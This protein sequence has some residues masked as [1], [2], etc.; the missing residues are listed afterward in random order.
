ME[1]FF[2]YLKRHELLEDVQALH[3]RSRAVI[4]YLQLKELDEDSK[5]Q[6]KFILK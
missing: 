4:Q 2:N 6:T 5:G 1:S 3:S